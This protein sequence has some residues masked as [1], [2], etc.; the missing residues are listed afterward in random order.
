[1]TALHETNY[2]GNQIC[3]NINETHLPCRVKAFMSIKTFYAATKHTNTKS[4]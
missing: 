3:C 2:L 1:M 4:I